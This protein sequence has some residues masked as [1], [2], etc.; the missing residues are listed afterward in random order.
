MPRS[1]A[2]RLDQFPPRRATCPTCAAWTHRVVNDE[3][4][5]S[6]YE[7]ERRRGEPPGPSDW[8]ET[9][10]ACGREIPTISI[11]HVPGDEWRGRRL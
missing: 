9:C 10:P 5:D 6:P 1:F 7:A 11:I 4:D 3:P 2:T 8:P